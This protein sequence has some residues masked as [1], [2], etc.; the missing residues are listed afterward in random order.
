MAYR[1]VTMVEVKEVLRL[2]LAGRKKK[3][4]ADQLGLDPKTVRRYVAVAERCGVRADLPALEDAHVEA[5]IVALKASTPRTRGTSWAL[6][7]QHRAFIEQKLGQ[8]VRLSKVCKLLRRQ[9]VMVAYATLHRFAVAE[10]G[11]GRAGATVPVADCEPGEEVQIDTG[12]MGLLEPDLFGRRRR[13]RAWI[14]T[15]VR[16][17]HRFVYPSFTETTADAI[18]ACEAAWEFFGGVFK[19]LLPDNTKSIVAKADALDAVINLEFLEYA[20]ARGCHVDPTRARKPR[21]KGRVERAVPT[22][23]D[24]CFG[25]ERLQSLEQAGAHA[26]H[27]CLHEY[28]MRPHTRTRRRPLEYFEAEEKAALLPAPSAAYDPPRW[29]DPKVARDQHAQVD[30]ALYSLPV[31]F[32]GKKLRARADRN[33][34]RLYRGNVVVKV[35]PRQPPGGRSTDPNDL[36]EHKRAYAQRD[37]ELLRSHARRHGQAVG[38]YAEAVL[39]SPLPWTRMRRVYALLHLCKRYGSQRVNDACAAALDVEMIDVR[40]LERIVQLAAPAA[41]SAA[42]PS[43]GAKVIAFTARFL[44]PREQYALPLRPPPAPATPTHGDHDP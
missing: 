36:P 18:A 6:C 34:V 40:R 9:G 13:W 29:S 31:H 38:D 35:H 11:F 20:Q 15:A 24:D 5:V 37:L 12:W 44:R 42:A 1:E 14:F 23:R 26:C 7:E 33:T 8:R 25:G 21:D 16:S 22:V 27:W 28:G 10:L 4:I 19:V 17:R 3:R 43:G 30:N 2:W 32:I 41:P 39:D